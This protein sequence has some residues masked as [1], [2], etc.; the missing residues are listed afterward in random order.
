MK[1]DFHIHTKASHD[2]IIRPIDLI[3]ETRKLGIIPAV[4][5][6]NSIGSFQAMK[7]LGAQFIPGEEVGTDR[8]DVIGLYISDCIPKRTP[9]SEALDRIHEQ[10]GITYLPH[11][12]DSTR[13]GIVPDKENIPKIDVIETFNARCFSQRY[14][15]KAEAFADKHNKLKAAGSDTHFLSEF[16]KTYTELPDFDLGNPKE[17]LK[18]LKKATLVKKK[19]PVYVKGTTTLLMLGK[20]LLG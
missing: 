14:N 17:L 5:D 6:H 10:G 12:F 4:T 9:F 1:I 7:N 18:A 19:A 16:G 2:S 3:A 20:K 8:G 15:D 13:A 11:M